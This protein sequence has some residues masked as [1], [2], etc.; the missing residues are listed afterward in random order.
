MRLFIGT[1][2]AL[3]LAAPLAAQPAV[4]AG[5]PRYAPGSGLDV[6]GMDPS[7]RPQD[8][9]FR[10]VNGR[11]VD[12]TPIP[13]DRSAYGSFDMLRDA[14]E[15]NVRAIIEDAA[16]GR[17]DDPDAARIGAAY[18]A[19]MDSARVEALGLA[20]LQPDLDRI[21]AVQSTA[22]LVRYF[23]ANRQSFGPSLVGGGVTVDRRNSGRHVVSLGQSG[24]A[25]PD[26]SYYLDD[27]FAD[28]RTGYLAYLE[29]LHE[30]A[31]LPDGAANARAILDLE[32]AIARAQWT[33]VQNRNPEATYNPRS[34]AELASAH[35]NLHLPHLLAGWGVGVDSVIV[36]QPSFLAAA[37]SLLGAVPL[38]TWKAWATARTISDAAGYLPAA[39][40]DARFDF[41]GRQLSGQQVQQARW[42]RAVDITEGMF[43]ESVGRI[44]VARHYPA[45]AAARMNALIENLREAFRASIGELTWMGE[46]TRAEA[47]RK[48]STYTYKIGH[49]SDW[50]AYEGLEARPDDLVGNVRRAAAWRH[51]DS[52]R[53]LGEAPDRT[54]WGMTPQTVNAYYSAAFNEIVFPAAILQPPFFNI[55]ADDAINYGGIGAVIGHEFSHGFD[56]QGSQFD[57]DGNLRSWWTPDDRAAFVEITDRLVAQYDGY[58]PFEDAAVNGRL[59]LGENIGDLSGLTMAWR[60]Y[61]RSLDRNGDGTVGP[62]EEAPVIGGFTGAQRFFMGWAQVWRTQFREARLRQQLETGPH[63]PGMYRAIGPLPHIDGFY[64][65]FN[66]QPGDAHYVAPEDRIRLW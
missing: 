8:D 4:G 11:W 38:S 46:A 15:A 60:A 41:Y 13:A 17:V 62:D 53:R 58:R 24:T 34:V 47:L 5:Q 42:K 29:R 65:A 39:F 44:Y 51:A 32:T 6:D 31:G 21:A 2:A 28:A 36:G 20:P 9:F 26:R 25:L 18:T 40:S 27:R 59:S 55:E 1:L 7:A 37:D 50:E 12:T 3:I 10:Y 22:D 61:Q 63:S 23:A 19:Y 57:A 52:V 16:A 14:S 45:A 33:R 49:P 64:E 54:R 43:G 35:P 48:L 30:L 66:V 56:D